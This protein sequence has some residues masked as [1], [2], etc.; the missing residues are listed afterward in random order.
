VELELDVTDAAGISRVVQQVLQECGRIDVGE[1]PQA[2]SN[3]VI[4]GRCTVTS[5]CSSMQA[6]RLGRCNLK[7][8]D[9]SA[10]VSAVRLPPAQR[11][12]LPISYPDN[13]ELCFMLARAVVNNAGALLK[14]WTTECPVDTARQ[15]MEVWSC[16]LSFA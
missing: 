3:P 1:A 7:V 8:A 16:L 14:A 15:L 4:L 6:D 10:A 5:W 2:R 13:A 9:G 11:L 12:Y